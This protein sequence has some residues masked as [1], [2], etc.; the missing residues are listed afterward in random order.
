MGDP[1]FGSIFGQGRAF[2]DIILFSV[3][4]C[5]EQNADESLR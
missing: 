3:I 2:L 1:V 4:I 5:L